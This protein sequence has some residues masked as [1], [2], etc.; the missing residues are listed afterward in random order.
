M[1]FFDLVTHVTAWVSEGAEGYLQI[2]RRH[3]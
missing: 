2:R 3:I 1:S